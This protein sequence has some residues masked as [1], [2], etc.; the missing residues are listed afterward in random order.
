[1]EKILIGKE[2]N[3]IN[4]KDLELQKAQTLIDEESIRHKIL[5]QTPK[6]S[7]CVWN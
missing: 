2:E 7:K 3:N 6:G 4:E 1:M 5:A